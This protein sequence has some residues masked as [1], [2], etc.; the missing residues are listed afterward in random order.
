MMKLYI[1]F[2]DPSPRLSILHSNCL[3][4]VLEGKIRCLFFFYKDFLAAIMCVDW[5]AEML[6][7]AG[8]VERSRAESPG[9]R[10]EVIVHLAS[11]G[12]VYP[13][14][15]ERRPVLETDLCC[16]LNNASPLILTV[17]V[18]IETASPFLV[19]LLL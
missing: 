1:I 7:P 11:I 2:I 15:G 16:M 4:N 10:P 5:G 6:W 12:P 18:V 3:N 14:E 17:P 19:Q 9:S 13:G 8:A